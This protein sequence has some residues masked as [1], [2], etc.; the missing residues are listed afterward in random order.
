[1]SSSVGIIGLGNMGFFSNF[2]FFYYYYFFQKKSCLSVA[3]NLVKAGRSVVA[4]DVH[5][6]AAERLLAAGGTVKI[7][8]SP[9]EVAQQVESL[10]TMLPSSPHVQ[11]VYEGRDGVLSGLQK[12]SLCIDSST[13]EPAVARSVAEAVGRSGSIMVRTFELHAS[14]PG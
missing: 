6:A 3:R 4:F 14:Q 1:M 5:R 13:I 7:A 11:E 2:F 9:K 8:S 12:G 10:V